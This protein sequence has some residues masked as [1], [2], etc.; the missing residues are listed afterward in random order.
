VQTLTLPDGRLLDHDTGPGDPDL[1]VLVFHHGTPQAGTRDRALDR[2]AADVGLRVVTTSRPGY[3]GSSR[4]AGRS[5]ADVAHDVE[6]LL[7]HL[8]VERCVTAGASGGGPH[9][10]ATAA[11]LPGRVAGVLTIAGVAPFDAGDLDFLAGM[12]EDNLEEFGLAL[13]GEA[14]LRPWLEEQVGP[15][16]SADPEAIIASMA[17]LLPEVDRAVVRGERGSELGED[18]AASFAEALRTGVDGWLDDDLAF[19]RPW[20]FDLD[21]VRCPALVYQGGLDLMVPPAHGA[22]LAGRLPTAEAHLLPDQGHLSL[23]AGHGT[24]MLR[25]L[26]ATLA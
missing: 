26:R 22:W 5:V 6:A 14:V 13:R 19:T 10:L 8:G 11:L 25:A 9:A 15:L 4:H 17:S 21:A 7:D 24:E 18:V 23:Q 3:G 16:R 20:G 12:G 2:A 1:P